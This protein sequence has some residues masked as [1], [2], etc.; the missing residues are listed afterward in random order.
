MPMKAFPN[1][2]P[3]FDL[4]PMKRITANGL[5]FFSVVLVYWAVVSC[6]KNLSAQYASFVK[7]LLS[8]NYILPA[9]AG[10]WRWDPA[11][12][13]NEQCK[14]FRDSYCINVE[15]RM[16][17]PYILWN[18]AKPECLFLLTTTKRRLPVFS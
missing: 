1:S 12:I 11:L 3:L 7:S 2:H 17:R 6:H 14:F 10:W 13:C 9:P 8:G 16:E 18:D 5:I 4:L 15:D